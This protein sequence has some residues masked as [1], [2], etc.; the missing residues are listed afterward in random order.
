MIVDRPS[1]GSAYFAE[2]SLLLLAVNT[3]YVHGLRTAVRPVSA[4]CRSL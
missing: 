4:Y 3:S 1:K 2:S